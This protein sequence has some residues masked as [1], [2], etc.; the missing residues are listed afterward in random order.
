MSTLRECIDKFEAA[1][2][3]R[4]DR[5]IRLIRAVVMSAPDWRHTIRVM[6][7]SWPLLPIGNACEQRSIT[8]LA[9]TGEHLG[10]PVKVVA[11]RDF[12]HVKPRPGGRP[13]GKRRL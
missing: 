7:Q 13:A 1:Q 12:R 11:L 10:L 6:A 4:G 9:E 2:A 5:P 3:T 8:H